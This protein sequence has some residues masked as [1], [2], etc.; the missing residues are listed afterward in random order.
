MYTE[1]T[2]SPPMPVLLVL[3]LVLCL[4]VHSGFGTRQSLYQTLWPT[5]GLTWLGGCILIFSV[6]SIL[7]LIN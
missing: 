7:V 4:L 5:T 2:V 1:D 3:V 6:I